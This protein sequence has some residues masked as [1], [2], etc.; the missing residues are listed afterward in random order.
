MIYLKQ[1][2]LEVASWTGMGVDARDQHILISIQA[3]VDGLQLFNNLCS[4]KKAGCSMKT[5]QECKEGLI[6]CSSSYNCRNVVFCC[7]LYNVGPCLQGA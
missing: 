7:C 6:A 2:V 4:K 1:D 3:T 5:A